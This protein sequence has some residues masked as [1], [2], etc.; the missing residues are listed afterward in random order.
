VTE[1]TIDE[2]LDRLDDGVRVTP[3][4]RGFR[5]KRGVPDSVFWLS[6][7][8]DDIPSKLLPILLEL[9]G[10]F[11]GA[12][13]DFEKFAARADDEQY[14]YH[15][16]WPT[17]DVVRQSPIKREI[18]YDVIGI[19]AA[20]L[21][22]QWSVSEGKMHEAFQQWCNRFQSEFSISITD[23]QYG[24]T[25][26]LSWSL[27]ITLFGHDISTYIP[28]ILHPGSNVTSVVENRLNPPTIPS[29][30]VIN[31][32]YDDPDATVYHHSTEIQF[33]VVIPSKH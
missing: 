29:V 2:I 15:L 30:V 3:D 8:D 6:P 19:R 17:F 24:D 22:Q 27:D 33:P 13:D 12:S 31:D 4:R 18:K 7:P 23:R 11:A 5:S 1:S 10:T 20:Q 9:E 28:F 21:A 14:Q 16:E 26:V 32:K 25:V